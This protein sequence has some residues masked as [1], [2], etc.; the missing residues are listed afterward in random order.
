MI[1]SGSSSSSSSVVTAAASH[2][3]NIRPRATSRTRFQPDHSA[4]IQS[5]TSVSLPDLPQERRS[6]ASSP[7]DS[8]ANMELSLDSIDAAL[9]GSTEYSSSSSP[10]S[11]QIVTSSIEKQTSNQ[12]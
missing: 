2:P 8:L 12:S 10:I 3:I 9:Q 7:S 6:L 4:D 5:L 1:S 11:S